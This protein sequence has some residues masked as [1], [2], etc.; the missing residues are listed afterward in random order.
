[1]DNL[2]RSLAPFSSDLWDHIDAAAVQAAKAVLTGRRFLEVEGPFGLGLTALEVGVDNF[3]RDPG[4]HEA[5]A[6][7]SR[8]LA[9]PMLRK[10]CRLSARRLAAYLDKGM[11]LNLTEIEDAAE[12]VARREEDII[13][14]GQPEFGLSGLLNADGRIELPRGDWGN[15]DTALNDVLA[16]VTALDDAGL[17]GPYA[18]VLPPVHYNN[19]FRHYEHTD[20]LQVEHLKSVCT[21]G[22]YKTLIDRPLVVDSHAGRLIIGQDLRVGY[23]GSDGIHYL[24]FVCE[25]LVLRLDEPGAVCVLAGQ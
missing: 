21:L 6:I 16:A 4:E 5:A 14:H 25:S 23:S 3:C 22:V 15:L 2:N 13:Y 17:H 8:A 1:M 19:L 12:A 11:P 24:L 9:V 18:L 7:G 10:S 20:L